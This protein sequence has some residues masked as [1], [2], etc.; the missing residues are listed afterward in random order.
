MRRDLQRR[1]RPAILA[2][3]LLCCAPAAAAAEEI[4]II[5]TGGSFSFRPLSSLGETPL[6]LVGTDGFFATLRPGTGATG[7][8]LVTPG[9][10]VRL[11]GS[12][13]GIHLPG[14]VVY[15]GETF[16]AVG[17]LD[18]PNQARVAFESSMFTL[19]SDGPGPITITAPFTLVGSF[20]GR[21]DRTLAP[22]TLQ[23]TFIGSGIAT[24]PFT[25][26]TGPV[27]HWNSG[28]ATLQLSTP[29]EAIPEP[30]SLMLLG[31]GL[32]GAYTARRRQ[33]RRSVESD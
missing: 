24:L 33:R 2:A 18:S 23:A 31:L 7:P 13:S 19:P 32:A 16:P 11:F 28:T 27:P 21:P 17:S 26:L 3:V 20:S 5:I 30:G 25:F 9:T 15:G 12:W 29:L 8:G 1:F 6:E 10:T 14:T 4:L 22:P